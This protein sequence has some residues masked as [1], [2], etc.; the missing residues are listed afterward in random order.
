MLVT[1]F[2]PVYNRAYI[3]TRL[4]ESLCRQTCKDF[5]WIVVDDG[6]TDNI[7]ELMHKF[8]E[9]KKIKIRYFKQPNGG[10]HRAINHGVREAHGEMFFIVDSDDYIP[11]DAIEFITVHSAEIY[12]EPAFAGISGIDRTIDGR[13][14]SNLGTDKY[15]DST[16]SDLRFVHGITGD[17]SEVFKT[18]T[19]KIFSFPEI[20]NE[21]FS[22]EALVWNRIANK[23]LILRYYPKVLKI[24]EYLPDGL[25]SA[26]VKIRMNSPVASTV[27]YS[28]LSRMDIPFIQ[29]IK[30]AVNYWRFWFCHSKINKPQIGLQWFWT[31]PLGFAMHLKDCYKVNK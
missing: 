28:E 22:P 7:D 10:K 1:V 25:T 3:I 19:L 30:A 24:I 12:Q 11:D 20:N 16:S 21:N 29:K 15:I 17:L 31:L 5:E 23:G 18:E 2:T 8:I 13:V 14:L 9:E 26:I 27:Y 4:Y 6:S